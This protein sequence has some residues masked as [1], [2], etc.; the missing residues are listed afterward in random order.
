MT[1]EAGIIGFRNRYVIT[2]YSI[3]YTKLYDQTYTHRTSDLADIEI[4][5]SPNTDLALWN[6][7]AHEIVY[8]HPE[9]I[10]WDFVKQNIIFAAGPVNIGYGM[11]RSDEKSR[12]NFV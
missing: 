8:N 9:A 3:H 6:Y 5:F 4:I 11:R 2:S 12:N 1:P 7:I 10:D